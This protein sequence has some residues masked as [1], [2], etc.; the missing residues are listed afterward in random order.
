MPLG[1]FTS[2]PSEALWLGVSLGNR[3]LG[4]LSFDWFDM[5]A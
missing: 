3:S 5:I 4:S 1:V 2:F